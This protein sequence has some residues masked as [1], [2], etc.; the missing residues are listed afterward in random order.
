MVSLP[1]KHKV[2]TNRA[3]KTNTALGIQ[4]EVNHIAWYEEKMP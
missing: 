4:K 3:Q 2:S 1:N